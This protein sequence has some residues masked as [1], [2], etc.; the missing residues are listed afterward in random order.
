MMIAAKQSV[1]KI[2]FDELL[3]EF[4]INFENS[5]RDTDFKNELVTKL[6]ECYQ[7]GKSFKQSFI[8]LLYWLFD[9]YGLVI[10]DPQDYR[11]K[12]IIK[13]HFH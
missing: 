13:T 3:N 1:G 8:E 10:F 4:F 11:G 6:K 12:I 9:S 2:N 5:L 7:V